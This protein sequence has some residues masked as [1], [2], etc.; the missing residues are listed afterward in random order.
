MGA[1]VFKFVQ[2][3]SGSF[4]PKAD[5]SKLQ[6][7]GGILKLGVRHL[8]TWL[9][10]IAFGVGGYL[11]GAR[12]ADAQWSAYLNDVMTMQRLYWVDSDL[13][14]LDQLRQRKVDEAIDGVEMVVVSGL[15]TLDVERANA[16]QLSKPVFAR[17][18]GELISYRTKYPTTS[19]VP[20]RHER[21][22]QIL[23]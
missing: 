22:R 18:K 23:R 6:T 13:V 17:M 19:I 5:L 4:R 2:Q 20:E 21:L 11:W 14:T 12:S 10:A 15:T 1:G 16:G 3:L 9:A 8:V 7:R